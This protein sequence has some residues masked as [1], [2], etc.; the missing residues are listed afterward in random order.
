[1]EA[2]ILFRLVVDRE[3]PC[4]EVAEAISKVD[5]ESTIL[6]KVGLATWAYCRF[7]KR[8]LSVVEDRMKDRFYSDGHSVF[9]TFNKESRAEQKYFISKSINKKIQNKPSSQVLLYFV[10]HKFLS[11]GRLYQMTVHD[12]ERIS[13]QKNWNAL[14]DPKSCYCWFKLENQTKSENLQ[15][16]S[17]NGSNITPE[18]ESLKLGDFGH[19]HGLDQ[20]R[21]SSKILRR[22]TGRTMSPPKSSIRHFDSISP[23]RDREFGDRRN[24]KMKSLRFVLEGSNTQL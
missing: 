11:E 4:E 22:S 7:R 8:D 2:D 23:Q 9:I 20:K 24:S 5:S 1:M 14:P 19:D 17:S 18:M 6:R 10:P 21:R 13:E 16:S 12:L 3:W 15:F